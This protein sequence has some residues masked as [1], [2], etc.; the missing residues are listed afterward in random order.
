MRDYILV[1]MILPKWEDNGKLRKEVSLLASYGK[2][3][4]MMIL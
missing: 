4:K 1:Q 3:G 2:V